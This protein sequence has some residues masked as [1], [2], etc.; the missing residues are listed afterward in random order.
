MRLPLTAPLLVIALTS[1]APAHEGPT[2]VVKDRMHA[3]DDIG[4]ATKLLGLL[5][6]GAIPHNAARA[7]TAANILETRMVLSLDKFP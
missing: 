1:A 3:M 5:A 2:G 6:Q 7:E 4:E